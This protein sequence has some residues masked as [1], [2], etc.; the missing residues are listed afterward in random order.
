MIALRTTDPLAWYFTPSTLSPPLSVLCVADLR[1]DQ[2]LVVRCVSQYM[3]RVE[4][5]C[6]CSHLLACA[7]VSALAGRSSAPAP[8]AAPRAA[9][10]SKPAAPAPVAHASSMPPAMPQQSGG[11]LSGLGRTIA[12]VRAA[13]SD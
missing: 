10:P 8:R 5:L 7:R 4:I 11:M 1:V 3:F 13:A 12:E 2:A 9:A 6:S